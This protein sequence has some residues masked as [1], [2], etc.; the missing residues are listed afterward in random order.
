MP[1]TIIQASD[2]S[3]FICCIAVLLLFSREGLKYVNYVRASN[4][5]G[6]SKISRYPQKDPFLGSDIAL[7]MV[8]AL[9]EHRFLLWLK[10]LHANV[11]PKTF[12]INFLG[13]RVIHTIE[14]ENM[15]AM[16][17][18]NWRD[19]GVAPMRNAGRASMPFAHHGVNTTD[20]L[21]W[22]FSRSLLEK[23]TDN[24]LALIPTDG[25]TFDM[26]PLLQRWVG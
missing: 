2:L 16:S 12:T 17:A 18:V 20:G 4:A 19:F 22:E 21:L 11:L 10:A 24:L 8:K 5:K 25:S 7:S 15:K 26:Q 13:T 9:K 6:C 3:V 14:P 1:I 23:H